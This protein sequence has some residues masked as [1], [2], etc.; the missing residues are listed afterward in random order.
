MLVVISINGFFDFK[1]NRSFM[2]LIIPFHVTLAKTCHRNSWVDLSA[3]GLLRLLRAE[4][5]I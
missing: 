1:R 2:Y 5:R 4:D 3:G